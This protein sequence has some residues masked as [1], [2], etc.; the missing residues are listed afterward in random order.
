[1]IC[2]KQNGGQCDVTIAQETT[3]NVF[4]WWYSAWKIKLNDLQQRKLAAG[5]TGNVTQQ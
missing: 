5:G 4:S 3:L 2:K 1:M